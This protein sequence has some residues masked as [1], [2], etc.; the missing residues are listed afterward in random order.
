MRIMQS[1]VT[2]YYQIPEYE[3]N[4]KIQS[5]FDGKNAIIF[6]KKPPKQVSFL[7]K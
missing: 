7:D 2:E 6:T 3:K 4:I 5:R 1:K